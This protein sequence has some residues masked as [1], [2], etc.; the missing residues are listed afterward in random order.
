[1]DTAPTGYR[2]VEIAER[3]HPDAVI[4]RAGLPGLSP[5]DLVHRLKR[6]APE[7]PVV[8]IVDSATEETAVRVLRVG[9]DG[10][11]L[12]ATVEFLEWTV[13]RV[14]EGGVVLD[15]QIARHLVDTLAQSVTREREWARA[16]AHQARHAEELAQT[17]TDF[18]AN[19][20]HE[21]RTP[22]TIIKGVAA[23]IARL[24]VDARQDREYLL[25]QVEQA[26]DKLSGTVDGMLT[27]AEIHRGEFSLDFR[28]CDLAPVMREGATD[29]ADRHPQIEVEIVVPPTLVAVADARAVRGVVR[30]LVDNACRYSEEGGAVRLKARLA[31][32]GVTVHITDRGFGVGRDKVAAAFGQAFSP[33]EEVLTKERSGLGIGLNLA[34]NLIALHGGILWAEPLPGGGSRLSFTIPEEGPTAGPSEGE[35]ASASTPT[36]SG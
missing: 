34:R 26:A 17:K 11:L 33:G 31:D 22:L 24:P 4:V 2:A 27:Q 8:M 18:L 19:V 28:R 16:L 6:P 23:T 1:M 7:R 36:P 32:E 25:E 20:S 3:T 13:E 29:A 12:P 10:V 15:P 9:A 35:P 5:V 21:L 30:Q 14:I